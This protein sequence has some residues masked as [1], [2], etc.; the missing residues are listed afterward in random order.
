[1]TKNNVPLII[2][3]DGKDAVIILKGLLDEPG[4]L[5]HLYENAGKIADAVLEGMVDAE[6]VDHKIGVNTDDVVIPEGQFEGLTPRNVT[7][8]YKD[9]GYLELTNILYENLPGEVQLA[10]NR[11]LTRYVK[12]RFA[13]LDPDG[14]SKRL[15]ENQCNIFLKTFDHAV[16]PRMAKE[17]T[18][19]T[20]FESYKDAK[21]FAPAGVKQAMVAEIIREY[22]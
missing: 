18:E 14:Y 12:E 13:N 5:K 10:I 19:M 15:S 2:M 7:E 11:E 1:M 8:S 21:E 22:K 16:T 3:G 17:I 6:P 9:K 20:G 4:A